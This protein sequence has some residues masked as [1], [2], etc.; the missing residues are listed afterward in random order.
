MRDDTE[1]VAPATIA[2]RLC[3][4]FRRRI[5]VTGAFCSPEI[6]YCASTIGTTS[7]IQRSRVSSS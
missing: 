5:S 4:N 2:A 1:E 3:T 6:G 7:L